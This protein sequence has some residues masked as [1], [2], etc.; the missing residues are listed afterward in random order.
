MKVRRILAIIGSLLLLPLLCLPAFAIGMDGALHL[1]CKLQ[2]NEQQIVFTGDKYALVKIADVFVDDTGELVYQTLPVYQQHDCDWNA[3]TAVQMKEKAKTLA[4]I[5]VQH[6]KY[7]ATAVVDQQGQAVFTELEPALYLVIRI[8][9]VDGH[10]RYQI[11]PFLVSI[12]MQWGG[13][14]QTSITASPKYGIPSPDEM[15][16]DTGQLKWPIPV[17]FLS[18]LVLMLCGWKRHKNADDD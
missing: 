6:K 7:V 4:A 11:D 14:L 10:D 17:L 18:G 1:N 12:P 5:A 16:P 9:T 13:S 3:L 8:E 2:S 15:L